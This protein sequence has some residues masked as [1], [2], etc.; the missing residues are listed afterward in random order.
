LLVARGIHANGILSV[1]GGRIGRRDHLRQRSLAREHRHP[2]RLPRDEASVRTTVHAGEKG[3]IS[4]SVAR[5]VGFRL[6]IPHCIEDPQLL[7]ARI[8]HHDGAIVK[9]RDTDHVPEVV[10]L[11]LGEY[12]D[13]DHGR[14]GDGHLRDV[15][16]RIRR[17]SPLAVGAAAG[18]QRQAGEGYSKAPRG[19]RMGRTPSRAIGAVHGGHVYGSELKTVGFLCAAVIS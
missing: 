14:V 1:H 11:A 7:A 2:P 4:R 13:F 6:Q 5:A 16:S 8:S 18:C 3:Q 12:A 19:R 10:T 15:A 17:A 9:Q